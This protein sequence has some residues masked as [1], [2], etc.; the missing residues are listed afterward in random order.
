MGSGIMKEL[1]EGTAPEEISR[2]ENF[3]EL[4]NSIRE[5]TTA[6]ETNGE[7]SSLDAYLQN[8]ALLTDQ[9]KEDV[10]PAGRMTGSKIQDPFRFDERPRH[11][12]VR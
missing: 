11:S 10:R 8:V 9:D 5:F 7:P 3:E 2:L 12:V 4:M 1:R 6:A